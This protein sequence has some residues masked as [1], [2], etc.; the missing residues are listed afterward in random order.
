M[1]K[2]AK[3]LIGLCMLIVLILLLLLVKNIN[4]KEE[5]EQSEDSIAFL[6]IESTDITNISYASADNQK[7]TF[8]INDGTWMYDEDNSFPLNQELITAMSTS[9]YGLNANRKIDQVDELS[10]YGLDIPKMVITITCSDDSVS[11]VY[12]GAENSATGDYYALLDD[13]TEVVY[14]LSSNVYTTFN[15]KLNDLADT[16]DFPVITSDN[17]NQITVKSSSD[18]YQLSENEDSS[19]GWYLTVNDENQMDADSEA[20]TTVRTN[21]AALTF[22]GLAEYRCADLSEYGLDNPQA[23]ITVDYTEKVVNDN[24][25]EDTSE[26]NTDDSNDTSSDPTETLNKQLV[27]SVGN[28]DGNSNY[29]VNLNGSKE[30]HTI[31]VDSLNEILS[32]NQDDFENMSIAY[33]NLTDVE[34][35]EVKNEN[36]DYILK[37]EEIAIEDEDGEDSSGNTETKYYVNNEAV[38]YSLFADFYYGINSIVGEKILKTEYTIQNPEFQLIYNMND[39]NTVDL[40]F[41]AYDTNYYLCQNQDGRNFL[42]NKFDYK[43]ILDNLDML[44]EKIN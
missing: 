10:E 12:I 30:I 9:F 27:I 16:D 41:V 40:Q 1:K 3:L 31:S 2:W 13:N 44:I 23:I 4:S 17:I 8:T 14:T 32:I 24:D 11:T 21:V 29:Y 7:L 25:N 26:K 43:E 18:N 19:T 34:T 39:G 33:I 36:G 6:N 15:Y 28:E 22:A 5:K 42:I 20:S 38:E 35:L 37:S